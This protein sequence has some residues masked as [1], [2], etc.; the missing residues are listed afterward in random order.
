MPFVP[1]IVVLYMCYDRGKHVI[2]REKQNCLE[3]ARPNR[4][5]R[6]IA[7]RACQSK[8]L[9]GR[10]VYLAGN[11]RCERLPPAG[12]AVVGLG[13]GMMALC[14]VVLCCVEYSCS[15]PYINN[16]AVVFASRK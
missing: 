12:W 4:I 9:C 3:A 2:Y 14:Y 16:S 8:A 11:H 6:T 1:G 7:R 5:E 13:V 10:R 15:R